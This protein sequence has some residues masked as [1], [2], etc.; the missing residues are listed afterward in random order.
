MGKETAATMISALC[1]P[2]HAAKIAQPPIE[3]SVATTLTLAKMGSAAFMR[4]RALRK[5][6][7]EL[8]GL[9]LRLSPPNKPASTS[10][11]V[12]VGYCATLSPPERSVS[13]SFRALEMAE[14][15]MIKSVVALYT[16]GGVYWCQFEDDDQIKA[17]L[18]PLVEALS[19]LEKPEILSLKARFYAKL[20]PMIWM[21]ADEQLSAWSI[22]CAGDMTTGEVIGIDRSTIHA[23]FTHHGWL[24][25]RLFGETED[26]GTPAASDGEWVDRYV[27]ISGGAMLWFVSETDLAQPL[28]SLALHFADVRMANDFSG[29]CFTVT[30]PLRFV[31]LRSSTLEELQTWAE[32]IMDTQAKL[33]ATKVALYRGRFFKGLQIRRTTSKAKGY[34]GDSHRR[35][36]EESSW[37]KFDF[38][39]N[40]SEAT[41]EVPELS[42]ALCDSRLS[43]L[44]ERI[45][46]SE[47][48][49]NELELL[50]GVRRSLGGAETPLWLSRQ[51]LDK[52]P[53]NERHRLL[54]L[55]DMDLEAKEVHFPDHPLQ[56][57]YSLAHSRMLEGILPRLCESGD[58]VSWAE[59]RQL[60]DFQKHSFALFLSEHVR[61][62]GGDADDGG[63]ASL[64]EWFGKPGSHAL[65]AAAL[66]GR[67]LSS[68][69]NSRRKFEL[70]L[71]SDH[72][73]ADAPMRITC[74]EESQRTISLQ[75]QPARLVHASKTAAA[76]PV[77]EPAMALG[78][79]LLELEKKIYQS[80]ASAF[81]GYMSQPKTRTAEAEKKRV[82]VLDVGLFHYIHCAAGLRYLSAWLQSIHAAENLDFINEVIAFKRIES[83]AA[84]KA[85]AQHIQAK[86][87]VPGAV[88]EVSLP[89][90]IA[91]E[92]TRGLQPKF[93]NLSLFDDAV[94]HVL[95]LVHQELWPRLEAAEGY[96][97]ARDVVAMTLARESSEAR[98]LIRIDRGE[99]ER[100]ILRVDKKMV[101]IGASNR[102]D[103][104]LHN[105]DDMVVLWIERSTTQNRT[106]VVAQ[107]WGKSTIQ[108][109]GA[110][111]AKLAPELNDGP[112]GPP[113]LWHRV[114]FGKPF[115]L[116]PLRITLFTDALRG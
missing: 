85:A 70:R 31:E 103:V 30:T 1:T 60:N 6:H 88:S 54:S 94:E 58:F 71:Q 114:H 65:R 55:S 83:L 36:V 13:K 46:Q 102:C 34:K 33:S 12:D 86:F 19:A 62:G 29:F 80:Q 111:S 101:L 81:D 37:L 93:P 104:Q 7:A 32:C 15:A 92:I 39:E 79:A 40:I 105:F 3:P 73:G 74:C 96:G 91:K 97:A 110:R 25:M 50:S 11:K 66:I 75:L 51:Q 41:S 8:F 67:I 24:A 113:P 100:H 99:S 38:D 109:G 5:Y 17:F 76:T 47:G 77:I 44:V 59:T 10:K 28:D 2:P 90:N 35:D 49:A 82:C 4:R 78:A 115:P 72:L 14:A 53:D 61:G 98:L 20:E 84:T 18:A 16:S 21:Q 69:D 95:S 107:L 48:L 116:N 9:N 64:E 87:L 57:A 68:P 26:D 112:S 27:V 108:S 106:C 89:V 56:R 22:G 45:A 43:G 52:I 23:D 63:W 42:S